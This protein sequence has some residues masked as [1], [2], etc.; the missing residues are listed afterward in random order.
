ML[1]N[2]EETKENRLDRWKSE[3]PGYAKQD[4]QRWVLIREN[5]HYFNVQEE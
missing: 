3:D 5:C 2:S 4:S 1:D